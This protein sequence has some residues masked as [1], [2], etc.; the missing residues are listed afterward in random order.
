MI[1]EKKVLPV[2]KMAIVGVLGA[3]S[4]IL[5]LTPLGF[6]PVGPTRANIWII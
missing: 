6:I 4:V 3:L 2:R 5:G 1:K